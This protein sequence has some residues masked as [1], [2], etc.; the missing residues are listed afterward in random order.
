M[1]DLTPD[2]AGHLHHQQLILLQVA[3]QLCQNVCR[4]HMGLSQVLA[5]DCPI[6]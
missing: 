4:L 6:L 5:V 1:T 2:G 3:V